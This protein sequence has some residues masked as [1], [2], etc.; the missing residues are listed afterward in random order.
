MMIW[1]RH[2]WS[3]LEKIWEKIK[4]VLDGE[5]VIDSSCERTSKRFLKNNFLLCCIFGELGSEEE[6]ER[7]LLLLFFL[8]GVGV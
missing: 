2:W 3:S 8:V 6:E 4:V 7:F 5:M 1:F